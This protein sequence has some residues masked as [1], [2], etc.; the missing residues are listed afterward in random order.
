MHRIML[1]ALALLLLTSNLRL[2]GDTFIHRETD[3]KLEGSLVMTM[4]DKFYVRLTSGETMFL[5][6]SEWRKGPDQS[7]PPVIE[8]ARLDEKAFA[9]M[10]EA[11]RTTKKSLDRALPLLVLALEKKEEEIAKARETM[12]A[13]HPKVELLRKEFDVLRSA[14]SPRIVALRKQLDKQMKLLRP[15]VKSRIRDLRAD[16]AKLAELYKLAHPKRQ[17]I[18]GQ[19]KDLNNLE[20]EFSATS[21]I[22]FFGCVGS[23]SRIVFLIDRS[24]SMF[25][26]FDYARGGL[27]S[28][29][30]KLSILQSFQIIFLSSKAEAFSRKGLVPATS[31]NRD[32]AKR[33][34]RGITAK[35]QGRLRPAIEK[36]FQ[37]RDG[38]ARS[39]DMI[40]LLCDGELRKGSVRLIK[41]LQSRRSKKVC[42]NTISWINP[43][44]CAA[45]K[46]IASENGG[47]YRH[48]TRDELQR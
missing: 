13:Q 4:S 14:G 20:H 37:A 30:D 33:F 48:V 3:K 34:L 28:C 32:A 1:A 5:H 31:E 44:S 23:G 24:G 40:F 18:V 6:M 26:T 9:K 42:I 45:M 2:Y 43:E 10:L 35:G 8:H 7:K 21:P 25:D 27:Q 29:I 39:V 15:A 46:K 47:T 41:R 11:I 38:K 22:T 19:I 16:D 36:A 12:T 17:A